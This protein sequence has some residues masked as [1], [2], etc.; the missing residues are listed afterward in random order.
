MD[1]LQDFC[2]PII[3]GFCYCVGFGLKK[4]SFF[5]D[6]YIP[7]AMIVLGA[8]SGILLNGIDFQNFM[9]G[10]ISGACATGVNQVYKQLRKDEGDET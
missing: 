5:N 8:I 9:M 1:I 7:I 2:L 10:A 3:V 6:K 4:A